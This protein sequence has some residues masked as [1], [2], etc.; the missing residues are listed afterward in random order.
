MRSL[1]GA[2]SAVLLVLLVASGAGASTTAEGMARPES[3]PGDS[4][5]YRGEWSRGDSTYEV[6]E[7]RTVRH[8]TD[9]A[10][11]RLR[12]L[13]VVSDEDGP[14][15]WHNETRW[16][17]TAGDVVRTNM[18]IITHE[19][20]GWR[21][22]GIEVDYA[23][24]CRH[25]VWPITTGASWTTSCEGERTILGVAQPHQE[26]TT[27]TVMEREEVDAFYAWP[28]V[29]KTPQGV[30]RS[31]YAS[32]ACGAVQEEVQG[33][34]VHVFLRLVSY[35]CRGA[36]FEVMDHADDD[37][38]LGSQT[39]DSPVANRATSD[40]ANGTGTAGD[41][42]SASPVPADTAQEATSFAPLILVLA[43]F[44]LARRRL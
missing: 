7:V 12:F 10:H 44:A 18:T 20:E 14:F 13:R 25:V 27:Y 23:E 26:S 42:K 28:V 32:E 17:D 30:V 38:R 21:R 43:V 11:D 4:W 40:V 35:S 36:S 34:D 37:D 5:T 2:S 19:P 24:P 22:I 16:H 39:T 15:S 33:E 8:G 6:E 3:Q 31:W 29:S 9:G 41:N 1:V